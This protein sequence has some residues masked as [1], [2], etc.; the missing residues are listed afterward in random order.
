MWVKL[1][2]CKVTTNT[3]K[4]RTVSIDVLG[5]TDIFGIFVKNIISLK[6]TQV[7]AKCKH[8]ARGIMEAK[9]VYKKQFQ[10]RPNSKRYT[11]FVIEFCLFLCS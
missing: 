10:E 11:F 7:K 6:T 8:V 9:L 2:M 3:V 1:E 5:L 4:D